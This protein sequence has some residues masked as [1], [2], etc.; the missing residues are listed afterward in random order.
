MPSQIRNF[1]GALRLDNGLKLIRWKNGSHELYNVTE[2]EGEG[3]RLD[4]TGAMA[5]AFKV[6]KL[7][8][9]SS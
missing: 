5:A 3:H 9:F 1:R 7:T 8:G 6:L 4:T 2:D